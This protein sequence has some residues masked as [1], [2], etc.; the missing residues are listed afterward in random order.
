MLNESLRSARKKYRD[1]IDIDIFEKFVNEDKSKSFK[2]V[3]KMCE[4][5][6][7]YKLSFIEVIDIFKKYQKYEQY[8]HN[9]DLTKMTLED[10][11]NTID[12]AMLIKVSSNKALKRR[13]KNRMLIYEKDNIKVYQINNFEDMYQYG[14]GTDWCIALNKSQFNL[15]NREYDIYVIQ[16]LNYDIEH[17]FRKICYLYN[18]DNEMIVDKNNIHYF[19]DTKEYNNLK[20]E[21]IPNI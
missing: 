5:Y 11:L 17:K 13:E 7:K 14:K 16:N 6:C 1:V 4:I 20:K 18:K 2:Y 9:K 8:I 3:E 19:S 10:I 21:L 12:E 15:Y